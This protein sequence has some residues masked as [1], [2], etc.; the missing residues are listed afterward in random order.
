M[1]I[2]V[3]VKRTFKVDGKE[4]NSVEE[5]PLDIRA[6]F[7]NAAG[8]QAGSGNLTHPASMQTKIVFNGT[9]YQSIDAIPQDVRQLYGKVLKSAETGV[10][11]SDIDIA[12][13][14]S[15]VLIETET[16]KTT[17]QGDI[18][19]TTRTEP[20]FS[21][22]ALLVSAIVVALILLLYYLFVGR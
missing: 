10:A 6:A 12:G 17:G 20:S 9:E 2:N 15:G 19:R 22:R 3:N 16:S 5:M 1:K 14:S 11:P 4:Y 7:K 8:S 13:I 21:P 18:R